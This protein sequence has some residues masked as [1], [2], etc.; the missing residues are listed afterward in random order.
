MKAWSATLL[1][2]YYR[3]IGLA[4]HFD[5]V[6]PSFAIKTVP[7]GYSEAPI[8]DFSASTTHITGN[9]IS[10]SQR[11]TRIRTIS[12]TSHTQ[13]SSANISN[14]HGNS[15]TITG[16][17]TFVSLTAAVIHIVRSKGPSN[18]RHLVWDCRYISKLSSNNSPTPRA[19]LSEL[20]CSMNS[21]PT[22][23]GS[24]TS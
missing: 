24:R 5:K 7:I 9:S 14:S 1:W 4:R 2:M 18:F 19:C 20:I 16:C 6:T 21:I 23:L 11:Y 8:R 12:E 15:T 3:R 13:V 22:G 10:D 17:S